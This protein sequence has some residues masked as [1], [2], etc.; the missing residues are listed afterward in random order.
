V[1]HKEYNKLVRD[2]IPEIIEA[3]GSIPKTRILG[4]V[5]HRG[6]IRDKFPEELREFDEAEVGGDKERILDELVDLQELL[7]AA[8][9]SRGFTLAERH[10][11]QMKK[12]EER[13]GFDEGIFLESVIKPEG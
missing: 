13:G 3:D 8:T 12:R 11:A 6:A 4:I 2:K 9:V 7:D 10:R 5:A 1:E